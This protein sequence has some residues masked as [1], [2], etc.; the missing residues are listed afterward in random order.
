[1]STARERSATAAFVSIANG[2]ADGVDTVELLCAITADC[3]RLLDVA[4]A[5]LLLA[6]GLGGLHLMAASSEGTRDLEMFQLQRAEGPCLD[7]Y[8]GGAPVL[9]PDLSLE[10]ER[11]PQFVGAALAAGFHSVHAL[12]MRMR[13]TVLGT[14]GLFGGR[15]GALTA[16][17]LALGQALAHVASIALLADRAVPDSAALGLQ[18][19]TALRHRVILEQAKGLVAE[20]GG[21]GTEASFAVLRCYARDHGLHLSALARQVVL[22]QIPAREVV[23]HAAPRPDGVP[24]RVA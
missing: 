11:W 7:C 15:P 6:D 20:V 14:V 13:D 24:D 8:Q 4:S 17:D 22:R 9:A 23:E 18:L 5:G 19:Q 2:L 3:A 16:E 1:M 12:P 10:A 21:T